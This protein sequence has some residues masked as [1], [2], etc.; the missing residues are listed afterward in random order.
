MCDYLC[1]PSRSI[2]STK[3]SLQARDSYRLVK[4]TNV[5]ASQ[6]F[7]RDSLSGIFW[8]FLHILMA[9][10][11]LAALLLLFCLDYGFAGRPSLSGVLTIPAME[12]V[13]NSQFP[14]DNLKNRTLLIFATTQESAQQ[15][16]HWGNVIGRRY[17]NK[18]A[19]WNHDSGQKVLV[20]PVLDVSSG[21]T[22]YVPG[23][24]LRFLIRQLGGEDHDAILLDSA[25]VIRNQ[26][27]PISSSQTLLLLLAP[28][29]KLLAY[30]I[31]DYSPERGKP[32]LAAIDSAVGS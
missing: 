1:L 23:W 3:K 5:F 13:G 6:T 9:A 31:G 7:I 2:V 28:H 26:F 25:G 29:S 16:K 17:V 15:S 11:P 14:Q 19:R 32:F 22:S 12:C 8:S 30:S 21:K 24:A 10:T 4:L 20:V 18:L 27:Q